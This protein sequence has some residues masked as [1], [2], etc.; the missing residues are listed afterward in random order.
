MKSWDTDDRI[1]E[2]DVN[3]RDVKT[4]EISRDICFVLFMVAC[5]I[6]YV[7]AFDFLDS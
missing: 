2:F 4:M 5:I 3:V 7:D 1:F 6:D